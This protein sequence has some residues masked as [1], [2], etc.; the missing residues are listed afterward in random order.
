M[1]T[2]SSCQGPAPSTRTACAFCG[3]SFTAPSAVTVSLERSKDGFSWRTAGTLVASATLVEGSWRL[4]DARNDHVVTL[5]ALTDDDGLALVGPEA[6]LVG[7]IRPHEGQGSGAMVAAVATDPDGD[8]VLVLRTDGE[9]AAHVVDAHGDVVALASWENEL[10]TTDLLV[11]PLGTRHSLG[12]VFGLL[13]SL[14][15]T[16]RVDTV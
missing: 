5:V 6:S 1:R 9:N 8:T 13:L 12:L 16:R 7:A 2:C 14:E 10:A 15:L 3:A 4:A 11:T